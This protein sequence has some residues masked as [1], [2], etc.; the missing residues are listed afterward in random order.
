M[1]NYVFFLGLTGA[2]IVSALAGVAALVVTLT[3]WRALLPAAD[4]GPRLR[5]LQDRR[6]RLKHELM[7]SQR[8]SRRGVTTTTGALRGLMTRMNALK[9][10]SSTKAQHQLM[11]AGF[12]GKDAVAVFL[13]M[14]LCL[15]MVFGL[16][17][18]VGIYLLKV[19]S[20][21]D[22][23][24]PVAAMGSVF[25]GWMAP[26]L[27]VKNAAERRRAA[28]TKALP[29]GL[30]LLTICVEAGLGLDA[31]LNRVA[32]EVQNLSPELAFE[33]QLTSIELTFLPDR[34]LAFENLSMRNDV[35]GIRGLVNTFRQTEKYGTPLAQSLKV[36]AAEY[37]NERMMRAEEKGARLPAMMTVPLMIFILPTLFIVIM[38]PAIINVLD[39]LKDL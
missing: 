4:Y 6:T 20:L 11:T 34:Q 16:A 25:L 33:L 38:G 5:A 17:A 14:K 2:D 8:R 29:E 31:A 24:K 7:G 13:F 10:D 3:A 32:R 23:L 27:F 26:D 36:L 37:R 30:D 39:N 9:G 1:M 35:P 21:P 12:R 18:V 19:I 22:M 28:I 15:P